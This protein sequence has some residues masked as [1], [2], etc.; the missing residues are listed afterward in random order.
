MILNSVEN[1]PFI[2]PTIEENGETRKK[3][4]E[5]LSATEKISSSLNCDLKATNNVLQGLPPNVYAIV[6]HHKVAKE[7]WDRVKLLIQGTSLVVVQQ[8]QERQ[9]QS[10]TS[11]GNKGNATSLG[12]NNAG[13]Q[14]RV[15]KCYNCQGEGHMARQCTQPKRP[16]NAAWFKEKAMLAEAHESGQVFN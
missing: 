16:R 15:L 6:N 9:V 1:C 2:W 5:E 13:G 10:H 11:E 12:A 8:V 3:K 14:D 7:I 4:Y